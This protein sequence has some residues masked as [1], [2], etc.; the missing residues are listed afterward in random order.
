[1]ELG[2]ENNVNPPH[3]LQFDNWLG[4]GEIKIKSCK[5]TLNRYCFAIVL[6]FASNLSSVSFEKML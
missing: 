1:M 3:T 5:C 6:F 2:Q 4:D